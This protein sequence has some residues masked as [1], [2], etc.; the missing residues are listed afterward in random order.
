M[1]GP[2]GCR[3]D[4]A[5]PSIDEEK[6]PDVRAKDLLR[7]M[8][9]EVEWQQFNET[10]ILEV[11]GSRGTYRIGLR[12][13]TRVVNSRSGLPFAS[14]CLQVAVRAPVHDRII[15]EYVLIRNDEDLYWRTANIFPADLDSRSFAVFWAALL[16]LMLL[17]I[18][19]TRLSG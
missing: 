5:Q 12:D 6:P 16:D 19:L 17:L 7:R 2:S 10:G 15:A 3:P 4:I 1:P 13:Q 9:P 18:L 11:A 14:A 8:L